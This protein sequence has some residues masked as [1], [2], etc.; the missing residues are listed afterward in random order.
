MVINISIKKER[1]P[2]LLYTKIQFKNFFLAIRY[3]FYKIFFCK[4][5]MIILKNIYHLYF[6]NIK[7]KIYKLIN[8]FN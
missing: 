1:E 4:L 7:L 2:E 3:K 5:F 6:L 8:K